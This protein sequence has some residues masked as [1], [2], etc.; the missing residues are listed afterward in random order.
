MEMLLEDGNKVNIL[1][2]HESDC[3]AMAIR[4]G[5]RDDAARFFGRSAQLLYAARP[6][7]ADDEVSS[8]AT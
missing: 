6:V 2:R 7:S 8:R 3:W 5:Q 4:N 1:S